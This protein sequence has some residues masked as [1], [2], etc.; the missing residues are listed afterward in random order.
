MYNR[1]PD[2]RICSKNS[3][4]LLGLVVFLSVIKKVVLVSELK[5]SLPF[6]SKLPENVLTFVLIKVTFLEPDNHLA[7]KSGSLFLQ[8]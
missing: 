5:N 3:G 6:L 8:R 7:V 1:F 4:G 2:G